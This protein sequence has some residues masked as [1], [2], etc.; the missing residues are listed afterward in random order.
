MNRRPTTRPVETLRRLG[1][2]ASGSVGELEA[3]AGIN[4]QCHAERA[5]LWNKFRHLSGDPLVMHAQ[6]M[7]HCASIA[8]RRINRR[9]ICLLRRHYY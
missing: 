4:V 2:W 5:A 7:D 3:L 9:E 6:V 1:G 8:L